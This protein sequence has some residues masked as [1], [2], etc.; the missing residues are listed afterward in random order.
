MADPI[1][2]VVVDDEP[3]ARRTLRLMLA[4]DP[5][6]TLVAECD[7]AE[8]VDLIPRECPDLLFLD[9]HM[10][11]LDGFELLERIGAG[12][13]PAVVFVTAFDEHALR[14]F[15]VDAV[16][17]LLKPFDDERFALTLRRV[18]AALAREFS[19]AGIPADAAD[20]PAPLRRF[21]IRTGDRL[22]VVRVEDVDWIEAA[23]YYAC[24]HAGTRTHLLRQTMSDLERQLDPRRFFRLYR[25]SI[26]N[27]ER[28]RE[29]VPDAEGGYAAVL[30]DGVSLPVGRGRFESLR[31]RLTT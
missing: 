27:L 21:I 12:T 2:A 4:A 15:E 14:A 10:P 7:A 18:K 8:A 20:A 16:D 5:E 30:A 19:A 23:D 26:V 28:V 3:I 22:A 29:L 13:V 1:R 9:I 17:Y 25:S 31:R 6:V 24:L 11:G